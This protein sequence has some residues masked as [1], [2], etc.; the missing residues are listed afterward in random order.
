MARGIAARALAG[1]RHFAFLNTAPGRVQHTSAV[2]RE[3]VTGIAYARRHSPPG[4]S[5]RGAT[6]LRVVDER[7]GSAVQQP[8]QE[9]T[10]AV[11]ELAAERAHE[12][13]VGVDAH[14][15]R[16][17][18]SSPSSANPTSI[19][20]ATASGSPMAAVHTAHQ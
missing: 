2:L 14:R 1:G 4:V 13:D 11:L 6:T 3:L 8:V 15:P 20:P 10:R 17:A 7:D 5:D 12:V 16:A 19:S 9:G 18:G